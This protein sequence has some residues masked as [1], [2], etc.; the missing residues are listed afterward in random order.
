MEGRDVLAVGQ[1]L[2]ELPADD[3]PVLLQ[4]PVV[5]EEMRIEEGLIPHQGRPPQVPV[6]GLQE[7]PAMV[8]D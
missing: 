4:D 7:A 3:L 6:D 1:E 8:L 5:G 2:V